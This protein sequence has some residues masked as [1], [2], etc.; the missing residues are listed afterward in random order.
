M[1][2]LNTKAKANTFWRSHLQPVS[3][4]FQRVYQV[5]GLKVWEKKVYSAQKE[6]IISKSQ[7][8]KRLLADPRTWILDLHMQSMKKTNLSNLIKNKRENID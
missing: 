4:N 6:G 2:T 8:L 5:H 1:T 7:Q 3:E